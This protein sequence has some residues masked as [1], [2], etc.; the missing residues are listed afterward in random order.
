MK[1]NQKVRLSRK[2]HSSIAICAPVAALFFGSLMVSA[3]TGDYL[4]SGTE[5][6]ITLGPG[7]Y[8]IM[9]YGA[10]GGIGQFGAT[11]GLGAQM[12]GQF[13][14]SSST[15]LTLLVGDVGG[16]GPD[17][18][19]ANATG[20]GGG[21]GSFVVNG[22]TPLVIAGGAGQIGESGAAGGGFAAGA[23]GSNGNGGNAG[24]ESG[25]GGGGGGIYTT[26]GTGAYD[27]GGGGSYLSGGA[28]GSGYYGSYLVGGGGGGEFGGY[29]GGGGGS[30]IDSSATAIISEVSGVDSPDSP[31][32]G[33][34]I[35]NAVPEPTTLALAG[36]GGLTLF[37]FPRQRKSCPRIQKPN[38]L[39]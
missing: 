24:N 15:I 30:Y 17:S 26:G 36:L 39:S 18:P 34:I 29:A 5:Q 13:N 35:I 4:Y 1:T 31:G 11:G 20:G 27:G 6:T 16:N 7:T 25:T 2:C 12:G 22:I 32:N 19:Q 21:G 33:E 23:G 10:Q 37:L 38:L 14:F 9:A 3:Q 28:G 8:D